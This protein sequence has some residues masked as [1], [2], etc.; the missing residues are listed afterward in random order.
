MSQDPPTYEELRARLE[1]AEAALAA[2]RRGEV[3]LVQ[4]ELGSLVV[5]LK[6]LVGENERLA[7]EWQTTLD[8]IQNAILLTDETYT[9]VHCN[10][11][12]AELFG[13]PLEQ[14]IGAKC[15][16]IV[17]RQA[18]PYY[19]CP[20][21]NVCKEK[22]RQ[23]MIFEQDGRWL[24]VSVDPVL[25]TSENFT[26]TV[27]VINDIT[28]RKQAEEALRA[29]LHR[30][31]V[32][33][34]I[35]QSLAQT[36]DLPSLCRIAYQHIAQLVDC[37]NF[38]VSLYDAAT[39][40]LRAEFILSDGEPL[41][42]SQ[43]PPLRIEGEPLR[44][45]GKALVTGR[46][47]VV[48]DLAA[49]RAQNG[50]AI[51][52]G[53]ERIP[54]SALYVPMIV[55]GQVRGLLEMQSYQPQAYQAQ[56]IELLAPIANQIGLSLENARLYRRAQQE[57]AERKQAEEALRHLEELYEGI[58]QDMTEGIML[59]D[60]AG[61]ITFANPALGAM[62]GYA[63]EELMGQP[64]QAFVPSNQQ[65]IAQDADARRAAGQS[66]RYEIELRRRDGAPV[67][68][69]VSSRPR[70][71]S[72]TGYFAGTLAVF[73]DFTERKRAEQE[74][75]KLQAQL[76]QAQKM[77]SVGRLAGG[78]AHDFNNML[79]VILGHA[80]MAL[81]QLGSDAPLRASLDEIR[82]AARRSADLTRQLLAF[83]RKQTVVPQVLD[84]N[85]TVEG[86][87]T[88]LRRLIGEDIDLVW[89]PG[90]NL[91][92]VFIDPS[93]VDQILVNLCVNAR[94]AIAGVGK[95]TI[96]TGN[97]SFDEACCAGHGGFVPGEFVLLAVSDDGCG[98]D[99][100]TQSH[101]FEPF[102]T[103]KGLGR[104]TGLGLATVYGAVRQNNGFI[105][106]YSEPGQGTTF[107]IYLPRHVAPATPQP[108]REAA[109]ALA[110][111]GETIL[112]VEDERAILE[113]TMTMLERLGYAVIAAA[114]P[115]EAIRLA[116]EHQGRIDLLMTDVIMPEMS[117]RDL[118]R[119]LMPI[120][121]DIKCLFMSGYTANAIAHR[122]V[123]DHGVHFLQ[124]PFLVK[125]LAAKIRE[126]LDR[127]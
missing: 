106:V 28:A 69:M 39:R 48:N 79:M 27:H 92:P 9:I 20:L 116:R 97:V 21:Q 63:P 66:D 15:Y 35:G 122:G 59:T 95:I 117:G 124:K 71:D 30:L 44:G 68:V 60:A 31:D 76:A 41:D 2:L 47:E 55:E 70:F 14:M 33:H 77:E 10:L 13:Q 101:L 45:R 26:S 105:N 64:W 83:A 78:V 86:M 52:I 23:M 51:H 115:G 61:R 62:L 32:L 24:E 109:P 118:A 18:L 73:T 1:Q 50:R 80:E 99:A 108:E 90:A 98:M 102:F 100:E 67:V 37:P 107:K 125:D 40:T 54:L 46:P 85:E 93:Q 65:A 123:L 74:K 34:R 103:T 38:G 94:D 96:E 19:A 4:G 82:K 3:D 56:D 42:V 12:A 17:H 111:G 11:A 89:L 29:S 127:K 119:N 16:Q 104:G 75:E 58:V 121:P 81:A 84:L 5:R 36:L 8:A 43:L 57:I 49:A 6:S 25:D 120:Y 91:G 22:K 110:A 114:T 72:D 7:R 87:L 126:V 113:M 53:N 88:M 112:L